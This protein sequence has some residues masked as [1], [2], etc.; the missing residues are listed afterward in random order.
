MRLHLVTADATKIVAD[1]QFVKHFNGLLGG[2]ER[3]LDEATSGSLQSTLSEMESNRF[4][5]SKIVKLPQ[6]KIIGS[7]NLLVLNLGDIRRFTLGDLDGAI[8]HATKMAVESGFKTIATP[9][10]GISDDVGLPMERAYRAVLR[11]LIS[12]VANSE[13]QA[14]ALSRITDVTIFDFSSEKVD[15][16]SRTTENILVELG[17][18]FRCLTNM[19]YDLQI[20]NFTKKDIASHEYPIAKSTTDD[21]KF[22]KPELIKVLFLAANPKDTQPLRLD[23]EIRE[24][25][26]AFRQA[27]YRNMFD[28]RQH[29]AVR[30]MD[31]QSHLLRHQPN[32]VHFSG[33]GNTSSNIILE[34]INGQS[35]AVSP[36]ALGQL[37][38]VL[39]DN[40][41]CVV[42]NACYSENQ[43]QAIAE[44]IDCVIGM[45][46]TI[47]DK[48]AIN[49]ATAFYHAL[50]YGR[51]V[52]TAF[53]LGCIQ[54][55]ME[56]LGEQDTPQL[57]A[58]RLNPKDIKF[59]K[60]V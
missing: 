40:I 35:Q 46:S 60:N 31:L 49:F 52:K 43:A 11:A 56:N 8:T 59:I 38:Y 28:I 50:G 55:D 34:N 20:E 39:K 30:I 58:N 18:S 41:R 36:K 26:M 10:I 51:D 21:G 1:L 23:E 3:V 44:H 25:D 4:L 29:W 7:K 48:A 15:F 17:V 13:N 19:E 53:D 42:L 12:A 24:I 6:N 9:V 2:A 45:S 5:N 33:H 47:S 32:I 16:F 54:I 37:F 22:D 27:E 14:N 57:I